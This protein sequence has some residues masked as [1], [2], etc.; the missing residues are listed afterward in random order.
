MVYYNNLCAATKEV[1]YLREYSSFI[2]L[3]LLSLL[4]RGHER[5]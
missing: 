2:S 3:F 1:F 5:L 4:K